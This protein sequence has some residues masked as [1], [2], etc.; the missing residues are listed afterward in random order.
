M[1]YSP[2]QIQKVRDILIGAQ[3]GVQVGRK[4]MIKCPMPDHNDGT[5]SMLIDEDNHF[6]CFGCNRHGSGWIDF[7]TQMGFSFKDIMQEYEGYNS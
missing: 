2:E 1:K 3:L 6:H 4:V 5:P 7:C